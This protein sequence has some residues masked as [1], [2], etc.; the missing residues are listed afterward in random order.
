MKNKRKQIRIL[1]ICRECRYFSND[2]L[3]GKICSSMEN[4]YYPDNENRAKLQSIKFKARQIPDECPYKLE[5]L[6]CNKKNKY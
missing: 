4:G 2:G 3:S 5:L 6:V 1:K